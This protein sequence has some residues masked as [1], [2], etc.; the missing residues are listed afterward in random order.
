MDGAAE[1]FGRTGAKARAFWTLNAALKG[2][3]STALS[4]FQLKRLKFLVAS[5]AGRGRPRDSRRGRRRY[6]EAGLHRFITGG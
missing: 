5:G 4:E 1:V 3:S 2:R 6:G